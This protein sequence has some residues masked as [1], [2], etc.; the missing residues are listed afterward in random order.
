MADSG[1]ERWTFIV[2]VENLVLTDAVSREFKVERV[3]FVHRD[4]LPY[5]RKRH[6]LAVPVSEL[7]KRQGGTSF[8]DQALAY[9]VVRQAGTRGEVER[10]CLEMVREELHLLSVSRQGYSRRG[11]GKPAVPKGEDVHS[12]ASFLS[13]RGRDGV[14]FRNFAATS[15]R[16]VMVLDGR[17]KRFQDRVLFTNLRKI[18]WRKTKVESSWRDDLRRA[19]LLV[20]ESADAND[21]LKSFIWNMAALE[22]LL[23]RQDQEK[24]EDALISRAEALLGWVLWGEVQDEEGRKRRV[25]VWELKDFKGWIETCVQERN[26]FLH[27]GKRKGITVK[28]L[29]FTDLLLLNIFA[30]LVRFPKLFPSKDEVIAFS[31]E[32]EAERTLDVKRPKVRPDGLMFWWPTT[33]RS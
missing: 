18:L 23:L 8:F 10:Q 30:N 20:G 19:A 9:A 2:P 25:S 3:T 1:R 27:N 16:N 32:L 22:T 6:G 7:E 15:P 33:F 17:W 21:L 5:V 28:L 31:K 24:T 4:R 14:P 11:N 13:V 26:G 29:A 12:H